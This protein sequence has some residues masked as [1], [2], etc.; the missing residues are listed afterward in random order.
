M[1]P[2]RPWESFRVSTQRIRVRVW[3]ARGT[4]LAGEFPCAGPIRDRATVR[5][6][7]E[8]LNRPTH[9]VPFFP[10]ERTKPVLLNKAAIR[11]IDCSVPPGDEINDFAE[12]RSVEL[13]LDDGEELHGKIEVSAPLGHTRTLDGLNES[14]RFLIL[15]TDDRTLVVNLSVVALAADS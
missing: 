8:L 7:A 9:F 13:L 3:L 12:E 6:L 1:T 2:Q 5:D 4:P 14:G 15:R 11:F 10:A